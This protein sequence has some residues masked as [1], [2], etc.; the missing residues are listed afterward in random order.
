MIG[1]IKGEEEVLVQFWPVFGSEKGIPN[2]AQFS[3]KWNC[4]NYGEYGVAWSYTGGYLLTMWISTGLST[5]SRISPFL[6]DLIK[7]RLW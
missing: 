4:S 5:Y 7:G 6:R 1:F 3:F 2:W